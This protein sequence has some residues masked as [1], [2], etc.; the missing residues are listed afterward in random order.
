MVLSNALQNQKVGG[1]L[2]SRN[3]FYFLM[4]FCS[5]CRSFIDVSLLT[6]SL[7]HRGFNTETIYLTGKIGSNKVSSLELLPFTIRNYY[8][9]TECMMLT[10]QSFCPYNE[11]NPT[12]RCVSSSGTPLTGWVTLLSLRF[13]NAYK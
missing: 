13:L 2:W 9:F 1:K 10:A 8:V 4:V 12:G 6:P 7:S 3:T 5:D 11:Q